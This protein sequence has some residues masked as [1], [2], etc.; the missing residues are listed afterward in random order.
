MR[1]LLSFMKLFYG[2]GNKIRKIYTPEELAYA[3]SYKC[4]MSNS[5]VQLVGF[6]K[7]KIEEIKNFL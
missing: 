3:L 6:E 1:F 2:N 5:V 7:K 4:G